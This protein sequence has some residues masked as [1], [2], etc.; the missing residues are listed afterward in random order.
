MPMNDWS[1]CT[2]NVSFTHY[3]LV[4]GLASVGTSFSTINLPNVLKNISSNN[5]GRAFVVKNDIVSTT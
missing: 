1:I 5:N 4:S 3:L 2:G